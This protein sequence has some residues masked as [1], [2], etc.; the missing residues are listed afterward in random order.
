MAFSVRGYCNTGNSLSA[1]NPKTNSIML[2]T[3]ARMGRRIKISV[4]FM[5]AY[6]SLGCG[7]ASLL[8]WIE[9]STITGE[10]LRSLI[11]PVVTMVS[12]SLTPVRMAIWSPRV[13]PVVTKLCL[14][15]SL[16]LP[17][18]SW[19]LASTR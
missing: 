18:S 7:V 4:K 17:V 8:G 2:T 6:W 13:S 16:G 9:L 3:V 11:C 14:A 5:A 10:P 12:P 1:R 19:P 15:T